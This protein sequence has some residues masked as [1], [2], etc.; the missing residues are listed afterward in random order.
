M[1]SNILITNFDIEIN[2]VQLFISQNQYKFS[3]EIDTTQNNKRFRIC[4]EAKYTNILIAKRAQ[5]IKGNA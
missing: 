2:N 1:C 5:R 3:W 4:Y